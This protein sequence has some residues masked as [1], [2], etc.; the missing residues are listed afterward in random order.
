MKRPTATELEEALQANHTISDQPK[1]S[2]RSYR[3][4]RTG[5]SDFVFLPSIYSVLGLKSYYDT[6]GTVWLH[7]MLRSVSSDAL[8]DMLRPSAAEEQE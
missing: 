6:V 4:N 1:R 8:L 5:W 2:N 7:A 3:S